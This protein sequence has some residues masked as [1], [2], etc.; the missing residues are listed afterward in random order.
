MLKPFFSMKSKR[1]WTNGLG[2]KDAAVSLQIYDKRTDLPFPQ[3]GW[4][5]FEAH[6]GSPAGYVTLKCMDDL[7]ELRTFLD[8]AIK[9]LADHPAQK[10]L[11]KGKER[12]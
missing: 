10:Q 4:V 6:I 12:G 9:S 3:P 11:K 1:T 2:L 5:N 8:I 7:S